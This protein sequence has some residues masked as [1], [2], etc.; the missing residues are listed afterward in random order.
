[1]TLRID[2]IHARRVWDSRGRPT[3]EVDVV[4]AGALG[5][6][7]APAG[8]S[9]GS[10]EAVDLRDGGAAFGGLDVMK[11][12]H[13]VETE[14][15]SALLG[16]DA[17]DQEAVDRRLVALDGTLNKARLG[18]NAIIATSMA[19]AHAAAAAKGMPLWQ[20]LAGGRTPATY[21][22]PRSRSSV[23]GRMPPAAST[24]RISW[25]SLSAPRITVPLSTGRPKCTAPPASS[26]RTPAA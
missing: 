13:A 10:G 21:R 23:A 14:I 15:A 9:T 2:R 4:A 17:D 20:H 6:A 3:V 7:I 16:Q 5:R 19:V 26:S 11:A 25:S 18:G 22:F 24:C 8:A 1:M 12:V